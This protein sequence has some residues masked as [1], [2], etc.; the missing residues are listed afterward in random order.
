MANSSPPAWALQTLDLATSDEEEIC[1]IIDDVT[2]H[3]HA[4]M[5]V[6]SINDGDKPLAVMIPWEAYVGLMARASAH[7]EKVAIVADEKRMGFATS[8]IKQAE[9]VEDWHGKAGPSPDQGKR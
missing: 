4:Y 2:D 8:V 9:Q 3:D 6:D 5:I 7:L 1:A